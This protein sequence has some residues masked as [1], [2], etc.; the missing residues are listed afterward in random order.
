MSLDMSVSGTMWFQDGSLVDI[1]GIGS[2]LL[3]TKKHGHKV[4]SK[5]YYI[6]KLK[7]SVVSLGQLEEGSC[8]I[9]I[10][11]GFCNVFDTQCSLL[12]RAPRVKNRLYLLAM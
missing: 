1:M 9:V 7:S 10:E 6:P 2:V 5:V 4:L 11:N 8:K 12:A 3:Q